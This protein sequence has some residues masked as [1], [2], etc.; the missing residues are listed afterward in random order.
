VLPVVELDRILVVGG[1]IG[2][3][4]AA[5][6]LARA[7][8]RVDLVE[9]DPGWRVLGAGLTVLGSTLRALGRVGVLDEVMD[10]GYFA[11]GNNIYS[12]K[13]NL[14]FQRPGMRM[15][16]AD[17]PSGGGIL[18][19]TL[20]NI[21]SAATK[22][23]KVNVRLGLSL[24]TITDG[25]YDAAVRF[26]DGSS[27]SYGLVI[28]ADGLQSTLRQEYFPDAPQ[29]AFTGQ[30]CWR[31]VI[32]RPAEIDRS[33]FYVGGPVTV[34]TV[35]VSQQQMYVWVLEHAPENPFV[36]P[37]TQHQKLAMLLADFGG[38][39]GRVRDELH[40]LSTI[41]YR[42][43][44]TILVPEP[45]Y[46]GRLLL[47]GDAAHATT[48]HLASGA[49][50]GIEDGVVIAEELSRAT[51]LDEAL[52]AHQRRRFERCRLVVETSLEIGRVEMAHQS[53]RINDIMNVAQAAIAQPF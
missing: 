7:G 36:D 3:M 27:E 15:P 49:G 21:L 52:A 17:L 12:Y 10:Q 30:G 19:P 11:Y 31:L 50:M 20:H 8:Y 13:G 1:G 9:R 5:I 45:W 22:K 34:G 51:T 43:L 6:S 46:R 25:P 44:E 48:P 4:S 14:L 28:A 26:S 33:S 39:V 53:E 29:P 40:T 32:D 16:D 35:P 38:A 41:V 37:E 47:S 23:A 2:G 18:R 42:P 24:E